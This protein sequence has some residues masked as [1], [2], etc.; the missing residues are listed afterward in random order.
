M[1]STGRETSDCSTY[2][3]IYPRITILDRCRGPVY[4]QI[5]RCGSCASER[6][7]IFALGLVLGV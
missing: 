3:E 7:C 5:D 2:S 4:T 6:T 1:A